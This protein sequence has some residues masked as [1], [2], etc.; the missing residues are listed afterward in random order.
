[1]ATNGGETLG[2]LVAALL[3]PVLGVRG[4]LLVDAASFLVSAALLGFL[5]GLRGPGRGSGPRPSFLADAAGGL[6]YLRGQAVVRAVALGYFAVVACTGID[7]V[8]L[9]FLATG[10]F[11][12]GGTAVGLLLA[13]VGIGLLAGYALLARTGGRLPMNGLL[14][15]GF[16]VSSAGNLL[17]GLAWAVA[18]AFAVQAVRGLGIAAMDV[19]A[20]T[21][22]QRTVPADLQGRVFG[23]LYGGIG[24]AAALAYLLGGL[25]LDRTSPRVAFVAAGA[26]GLLATGAT[27]LALRRAVHRS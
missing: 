7:D 5:P 4:V 8:A 2:P 23:S 16:A 10:T 12:A 6:R 9:V 22:V 14:L 19:A 20:T 26:A 21:L 17:T 15:A 13:A 24:V 18:A 27:A 1:V 11:G 25:L 3:L